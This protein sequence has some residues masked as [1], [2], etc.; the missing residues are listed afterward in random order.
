MPN[1][2]S[3]STLQ[4]QSPVNSQGPMTLLPPDAADG[5]FQQA[6][7]NADFNSQVPSS[8]FVPAL[9]W[10]GDA[11]SLDFLTNSLPA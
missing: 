3:A 6:A 10:S 8:G 1:L 5:F 4:D 11:N 7:N 9:D 2:T